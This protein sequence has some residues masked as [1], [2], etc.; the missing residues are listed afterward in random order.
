MTKHAVEWQSEE[1]NEETGQTGP[2]QLHDCW[3]SKDQWSTNIK[4]FTRLSLKEMMGV[5]QLFCRFDEERKRGSKE[6]LVQDAKW[7][8]GSSTASDSW[9]RPKPG[10]TPWGKRVRRIL[11]SWRRRNGG[12]SENWIIY[13]SLTNESDDLL[14]IESVF[15]SCCFFWS[16]SSMFHSQYSARRAFPSFPYLSILPSQCH[17]AHF[18]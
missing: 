13:S 7:M 9:I 18:N 1:G 6:L 8:S 5:R 4:S 10:G 12:A 17:P 2:H 11:S 16:S 14:P 3:R 15:S